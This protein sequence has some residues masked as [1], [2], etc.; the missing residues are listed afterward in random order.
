MYLKIFDDGLHLWNDLSLYFK[1]LLVV[2]V[3]SGSVLG[4]RYV[5]GTIMKYRVSKGLLPI[6]LKEFPVYQADRQRYAEIKNR[7][8]NFINL[9]LN[10]QSSILRLSS[11]DINEMFL[12]GRSRSKASPGRHDYYKIEDERIIQ[13][14]IEWPEITR[15]GCYTQRREITF[16]QR[17]EDWIENSHFFNSQD[18][19]LSSPKECYSNVRLRDSKIVSN[20]LGVTQYT[21]ILKRTDPERYE[22]YARL[23][24]SF[25]E[26]KIKDNTLTFVS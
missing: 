1:F 5:F 12:M 18:H 23:T 22:E 15:D 3:V 2:Y 16:S 25:K 10:G 7:C 19:L 4:Y 17:Q 14:T 11:S 24:E 21:G 9:T 13:T 8:D 26:V 6:R 20:V